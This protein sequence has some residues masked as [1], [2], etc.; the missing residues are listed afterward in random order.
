MAT[1]RPAGRPAKPV[2]VHRATGN[3]SKKVLPPAPMPGQGLVSTVGIPTPPDDLFDDGLS[4]WNYIWE[5][6]RTWLSPDSDYLIVRRLC[7]AEDEYQQIRRA[8][9]DGTIRRYYEVANGQLVSHPI[10][11]QYEKLRVQMTAWMAAIGFSPSDRA[12][13][14]LAEVRVRNELDELAERR[15]NRATQA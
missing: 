14:G 12:R 4:L 1:G 15:A 2:E 5:A 3:P 9:W 6:G 13:L 11:G 10:V 7:E 8:I